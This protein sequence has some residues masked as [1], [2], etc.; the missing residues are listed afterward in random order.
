M[1][2]PYQELALPPAYLSGSLWLRNPLDGKAAVLEE[3]FYMYSLLDTLY[4]CILEGMYK[5]MYFT[6]DLRDF[7][8]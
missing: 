2:K 7:Q 3:D 6:G 1:S 8:A 5:S 4:S